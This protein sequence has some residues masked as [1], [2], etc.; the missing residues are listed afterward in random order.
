MMTLT[1]YFKN[2]KIK[3]EMILLNYIS[4]LLEMF[5]CSK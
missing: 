2:I 3:E 5:L 4:K 1:T